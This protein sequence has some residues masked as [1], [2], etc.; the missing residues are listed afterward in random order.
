M[1]RLRVV[2]AS[3][4]FALRRE[5]IRSLM[6]ENHEVH[7][8]YNGNEALELA[9]TKSADMVIAE[10][11]LAGLSGRDLCRRLRPFPL[12]IQIPFTYLIADDTAAGNPHAEVHRG[13]DVMV[14]RTDVGELIAR[15]AFRVDNLPRVVRMGLSEGAPAAKAAG[16]P[17]VKAPA[18][19]SAVA[20]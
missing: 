15:R 10:D 4:N 20:A 12:S 1:R 16:F 13:I 17:G 2:V 9:R 18:G 5:L 14:N 3:G 8:A 7:I 19:K 6:L 11:C